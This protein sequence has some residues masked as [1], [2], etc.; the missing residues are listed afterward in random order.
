VPPLTVPIFAI[1]AELMAA[2][3]QRRMLL[4]RHPVRGLC[5]FRLP[6]ALG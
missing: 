6:Q 3:A 5:Y 2:L 4:A 1:S